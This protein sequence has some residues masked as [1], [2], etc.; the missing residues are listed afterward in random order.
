MP[1]F[2]NAG[3]AALCAGL[4]ALALHAPAHAAPGAEA[5]SKLDL[6]GYV[7]LERATTDASGKQRLERV[8]PDVVT[9]GDRLIFGTRFTNRG[10]APIEGFVLS[11]PVPASVSLAET[12][13][14]AVLVSVDGGATWGKLAELAVTGTGGGSRPALPGDVTNIRWVLPQIAPGQSGTLEF[15][16]TVR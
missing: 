10:P 4:G 9:P 13:D 2:R 5:A 12:P 14:P 16:V 6:A 8:E 11:N 7:M 1:M 15:P 3:R